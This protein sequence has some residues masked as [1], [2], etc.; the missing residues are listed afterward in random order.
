MR[1]GEQRVLATGANNTT[2]ITNSTIAF[3]NGG[4]RATNGGGLL[5]SQ[6][7]I[8]VAN[9]IVASNTVTNPLTGGQTPSNCGAT[10]PGVINSLGDNLET[11]ADC[12]FKAAGDLQNT[13]PGFLT[14]GLA[15]NGGNTETFALSG[16][17]PAVDAVAATAPGCSGTDQRD[18][19]R[20]QGTGC[21]IG[22]Y[23]LFQPVE[24]QQFTT[25]VGRIGATTCHDRL[26]G[27]HPSRRAR[28]TRSG[29]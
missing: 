4:S 29:R 25:V 17:S 12:G 14:G 18:V 22:A 11:A 20:P 9:S 15:Y 3:N 8:S 7:T 6:G 13:S 10:S 26:G 21:D 2:T 24:G 16:A 1:R 27:Q 23:E 28:S 5:A 19:A